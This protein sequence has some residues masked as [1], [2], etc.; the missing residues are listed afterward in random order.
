MEY[1]I[2]MAKESDKA[3]ILSLYKLQIGR[4]YC[5][6]SEDYPSDETIDTDISRNALFV[7]RSGG[8]IISAISIEEDES[9]DALPF[10]SRNIEPTGELAR[11][12]VTPEK[13]NQ[14]IGRIMLR[15]G[16]EELKRRGFKG[17]RFL[18]EKHNKKA[19]SCY[20]D[21]DFSVVGECHMYEQD[22]L[23]YE[24]EL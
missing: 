22:F 10:W 24:K 15:F 1:K 12:A 8:K 20:A 2:V 23:C 11:L 6:W 19:I 3:E 9:V 14:G 17:I 16:M 21:F 4:K 5:P 7:M 18:V 13:Q